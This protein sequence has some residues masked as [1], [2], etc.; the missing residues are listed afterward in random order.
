MLHP[1]DIILSLKKLKGISAVN[2]LHG[3]VII[4]SS[5]INAGRIRLE[6]ESSGRI[7]YAYITEA[8]AS[9]MKL[10]PGKKIYIIFKG[11]SLQWI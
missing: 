6:I 7:F 10:F 4:M 2:M 1:G 8:S 11:T 3:A 5:D 9:K